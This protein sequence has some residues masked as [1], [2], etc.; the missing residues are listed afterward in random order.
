MM[1]TEY[2]G[3]D[4]PDKGQRGG[5][6]NRSACQQAGATFYNTSTMRWYCPACAA[7]INHWSV[8]DD[9]V[10]LC[11]PEGHPDAPKA[12]KPFVTK[13]GG[14]LALMAP[15]YQQAVVWAAAAGL[16]DEQ[17]TYVADGGELSLL[18]PSTTVCVV[19]SGLSRQQRLALQQAVA[20]QRVQLSTLEEQFPNNAELH[21]ML[22]RDREEGRRQ[23]FEGLKRQRGG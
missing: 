21:E 8:L 7:K 10:I 15:D 23:R 3:P 1:A 13:R 18:W 19:G 4:K 12:A 9:N 6:C 22:R 16:G 5:S 2:Q 17:W 14:V 11:V 20:T